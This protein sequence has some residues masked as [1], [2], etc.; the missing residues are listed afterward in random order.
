[1]SLAFIIQIYSFFV[2]NREAFRFHISDAMKP[3]SIE[4]MEFRSSYMILWSTLH[5]NARAFTP[6]KRKRRKYIGQ[7][8]QQTY[9]REEKNVQWFYD[10]ATLTICIFFSLKHTL[11]LLP[12]LF[13]FHQK[14]SN[15]FSFTF[16]CFSFPAFGCCWSCS[17]ARLSRFFSSSSSSSMLIFSS[18]WLS[19]VSEWCGSVSVFLWFVFISMPHSSGPLLNCYNTQY[20][21]VQ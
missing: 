16:S 7:I 18:G 15:A 5:S 6:T 21:H 8:F 17:S 3:N 11:T 4:W 20:P 1:M 14:F 2:W 12:F 10:I 9:Q 13:L 19:L